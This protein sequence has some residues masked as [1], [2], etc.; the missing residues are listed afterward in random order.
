MDIVTGHIDRVVLAVAAAI[1]I[2][3]GLIQPARDKAN[4]VQATVK[5]APKIQCIAL[6]ALGY[7][8][9]GVSGTV[10]G[11]FTTGRAWL[12][13]RATEG[14]DWALGGVGV[15]ALAVAALLLLADYIAP[16]GLEPNSGKPWG[17]L[18]M[19]LVALLVYPLL[20]LA[21]GSMSLFSLV[22]I[23]VVMWFINVKFRKKKKSPATATA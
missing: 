14:A 7:G 9:T 16:G 10:A 8:I 6:T 23:F 15:L 1:F 12:L 5:F 17:H 20:V 13:D 4:F 21:L 18:L 2:V 22:A 19:W 11:W 3:Y